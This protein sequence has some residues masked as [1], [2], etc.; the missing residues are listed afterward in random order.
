MFSPPFPGAGVRLLRKGLYPG[1][2]QAEDPW[3]LP[4]NRAAAAAAKTCHRFVCVK[5]CV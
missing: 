5:R 1:I 2:H 3:K 4:I